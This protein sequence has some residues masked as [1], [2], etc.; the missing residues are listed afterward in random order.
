MTA[1][2]DTA[3]TAP[4]PLPEDPPAL[5]RRLVMQSRTFAAEGGIELRDT[6]AQLFRLLVLA[7]L[8][9]APVQH[10][11]ALRASRSLRPFTRSAAA[12][13]RTEPE[14]VSKAL[15]TA[16]YWRFHQTKATLLVRAAS[17]VVD[18]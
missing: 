12:L 13:A 9:A 15:T 11:T 5:L 16:G 10:A 4:P 1:L 18:R 7:C 6:P 17:D 3:T 14:E 2:D 8:L